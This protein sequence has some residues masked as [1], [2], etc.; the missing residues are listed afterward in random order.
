MDPNKPQESSPFATVNFN[1]GAHSTE[2][3][4]DDLDPPY[5]S[6]SYLS[7]ITNDDNQQSTQ[8]ATTANASI[9]IFEILSTFLPYIALIVGGFFLL[10]AFLLFT[11]SSDGV[12]TLSWKST[13]WP[14]YTL[15]AMICL[16]FGY[17]CCPNKSS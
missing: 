12:L 7:N 11:F 15:I 4:M 1:P 9:S 17:C 16:G 5:Q 8:K 3:K 2:F 10:L 6:P 14:I 13:Y